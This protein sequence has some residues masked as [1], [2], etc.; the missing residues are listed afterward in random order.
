MA[1]LEGKEYLFIDPG[2]VRKPQI[3]DDVARH[4]ELIHECLETCSEGTS[5]LEIF[6]S[7]I[8][9]TYALGYTA[10]VTIDTP[11]SASADTLTI[12]LVL[13]ERQHW[14][15]AEVPIFHADVGGAQHH[16]AE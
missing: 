16:T 11:I 12:P 8:N 6:D 13:Y 4:F 2:G 9:L 5:A 10:F 3:Y 14:N 15:K 1:N 7:P